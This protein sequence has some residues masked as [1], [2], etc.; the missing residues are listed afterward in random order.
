MAQLH[1]E[2]IVQM[3][4][5]LLLLIGWQNLMEWL[6]LKMADQQEEEVCIGKDYHA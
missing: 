5:S 1:L 6:L 3:S 2:P 4:C